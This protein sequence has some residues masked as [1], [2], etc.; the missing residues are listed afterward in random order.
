MEIASILTELVSLGPI[1]HEQSTKLRY[2]SIPIK[3]GQHILSTD[4]NPFRNLDVTVHNISFTKVVDCKYTPGNSPALSL[5]STTT[6]NSG[7]RSP[8]AV[9]CG[10]P[11][12]HP[13]ISF[14]KKL[15]LH[16]SKILKRL[17]KY[18]HTQN[19]Q[20]YFFSSYKVADK[21]ALL[22]VRL[23]AHLE[24]RVQKYATQPYSDEVPE[25][26]SVVIQIQGIWLYD[27]YFGFSLKLLQV[28]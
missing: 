28:G 15:Q 11:L 18:Q 7:M 20:Q 8:K 19:L 26:K 16:V 6:T 12:N 14:L 25:P 13:F 3:L 22:T 1:L 10:I 21:N 24:S 17:S 2:P 4:H 27:L 5:F 23:P 9:Q